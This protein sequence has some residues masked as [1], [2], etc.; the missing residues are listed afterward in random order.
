M[1]SETPHSTRQEGLPGIFLVLLVL[2]LFIPIPASGEESCTEL[3]VT[4]CETCHYLTR[5]CEKVNRER[6]KKSWLGRGKD[7]TSTWSR[8]VRNMVRQGAQLTKAEE[9]RLIKCLSRPAP[10]IFSLCHFKE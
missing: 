5:V 10:E 4:R 8:T 2:G 9:K 7:S 6:N 3:L 1:N